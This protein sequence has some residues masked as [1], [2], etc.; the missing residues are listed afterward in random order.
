MTFDG[1]SIDVAEL[2]VPR[3]LYFVIVDLGA[4]KDTKEI[5]NRLNHCYP[6]AENE[7]EK[8]VQNYLG[9]ISAA[10]VAEAVEAIRAGDAERIGRL[11]RKAQ[12]EFDRY[13]L[14]ACPA[15]LTAPALHRVLNYPAIQPYILG[16]KGVGSQGDGSAQFIVK[17]AESQQQVIAILE[18]EL[19]LTCLK[20]VLHSGRRVRKALIP[21]AGFG[22]RLFPATKTLKKELFPIIDREGRI[23]PVILTIV[24]EALNA[25]IEEVGIVVQARD[26]GIFEEF[27]NSPPPIENFNKLSHESQEYSRYLLELGRHVTLIPQ[28]TQE[29][30]GHAVYCARDWIGKEPFLLMLGDHVYTAESE[31]SC[32]RQLLDVYERTGQNVVG[33][34]T[35]PGNEVA[36]FGC[37]GGT[38]AED[39]ILAISEFVEKPDVEY[40]RKQLLIEGLDNDTFLSFFGLYI[41]SPSIFD[42]LEDHIRHNVRERGEFQL[43]SCLDRLR[44]EEGFIGY[45]VK[46][47]RFDIGQPDAY[48][49]ALIHFRNA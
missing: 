46:G 25:G 23:K 29:G 47:R 42:Y 17:D 30:F 7:L 9:P 1:D 14:P 19:K 21:A 45:V 48:R 37:A 18:R 49:D 31:R 24:E 6:F 11:M 5:L 38:W 32:A 13:C 16:G 28:E 40:A 8:G 2:N 26:R 36:R 33:L 12:A 39:A 15:Q 43:T 35:T 27:F 10:I 4:G 3:D 34:R 41:L 22:T 20:L 44:Q